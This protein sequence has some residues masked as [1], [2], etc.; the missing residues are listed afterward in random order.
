M[1]KLTFLL[2]LCGSGKTTL[3]NGLRHRQERSSSAI[4]YGTKTRTFL[5]L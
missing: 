3:L 2:G 4:F 5:C 1:A